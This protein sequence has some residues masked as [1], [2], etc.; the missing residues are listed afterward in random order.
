MADPERFDADPDP[1]FQADANPD[2][3]LLLGL[4]IFFLQISIYCFQSLQKLV[5]CNFSARMREEGI[6]G[7]G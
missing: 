2:P 6:R 1:T 7:E 5:M 3:I 4:D